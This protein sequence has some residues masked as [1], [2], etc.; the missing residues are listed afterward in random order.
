MTKYFPKWT[1][2][3]KSRATSQDDAVRQR[4]AQLV[5]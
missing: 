4:G 2:P 5:V 1:G 3:Y